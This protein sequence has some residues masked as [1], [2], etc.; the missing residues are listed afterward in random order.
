MS[1]GPQSY[2]RLGK[3]GLRKRYGYTNGFVKPGTKLAKRRAARRV[4]HTK[5]VSDGKEYRKLWGYW[6]WC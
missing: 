1:H 6:E 5:D 4:R 2:L 3:K